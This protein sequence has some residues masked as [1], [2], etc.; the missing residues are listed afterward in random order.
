MN[1]RLR[2]PS[3]I[4]VAVLLAVSLAYANGCSSTATPAR[5]AY[6]TISDAVSAAQQAMLAFNAQYQAGLATEAQRTKALG[7]YADFQATARTAVT[8]SKDVT[9]QA[10]ALQIAS[11]AASNLL[12]LLAQ[13][14]PAS[15]VPT[16]IPPVSTSAPAATTGG[17]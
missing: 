15:A 6:T 1:R 12:A 14:L 11:D 10:N 9:Q 4:G 5:K 16:A 2:L 8:L 13:L 3:A 7:Y 17:A